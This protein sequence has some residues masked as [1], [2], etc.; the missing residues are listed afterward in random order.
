MGTA[1]EIAGFSANLSRERHTQM[2]ASCSSLAAWQA[3]SA[4]LQILQR[5]SS[6][7]MV[8]VH[9]IAKSNLQLLHRTLSY[10]AIYSEHI[11]S[12]QREADRNSLPA[13]QRLHTEHGLTADLLV[14]Q[15]GESIN[16]TAR[17]QCYAMY[18]LISGSAQLDTVAG[19]NHTAKHWWNRISTG[20]NR[21][22]LR[23]GAVIT[24]VDK[25][26]KGR[27]SAKGKN[28]L[29]LKI[30]TSMLETPCKDV[31]LN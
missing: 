21:N 9:E 3:F 24:P 5:F 25:Q 6:R 13:L 16:L 1:Q 2:P 8:N 29:L 23:S 10:D 20:G 31:S 17:P 30:N 27:I 15:N 11:K 18:L 12:I 19:N 7:S 26:Q 4:G 14:V 28:C 22:S